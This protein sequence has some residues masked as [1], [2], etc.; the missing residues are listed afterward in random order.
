MKASRTQ[1]I[2]E[3]HEFEDLQHL[4]CSFFH[5]STEIEQALW[6]DQLK[7]GSAELGSEH[8]ALLVGTLP[9]RIWEV[10]VDRGQ[11]SGGEESRDFDPRIC[12]HYFQ[13][14]GAPLASAPVQFACELLPP[15]QRDVPHLWKLAHIIERKSPRAAAD[16]QLQWS[17]AAK[18]LGPIG[19]RGQAN[20]F[21]TNWIR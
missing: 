20:Q 21:L 4:Q 3:P 5:V 18:H 14:H 9:P 16:F 1:R 12:L 7:E 19:W 15:F 6:S 10:E 11:R 13:V 8:R 2:S 17:I